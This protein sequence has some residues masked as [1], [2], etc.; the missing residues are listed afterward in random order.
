MYSFNA[1]IMKRLIKRIPIHG[2][3]D[4]SMD[5]ANCI[6]LVTRTNAFVNDRN[7][8]KILGIGNVDDKQ[9]L[10]DTIVKFFDPDNKKYIITNWL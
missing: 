6:S 8:K 5:S 1:S 9:D 4:Q 3:A 7:Y 2:A 10:A